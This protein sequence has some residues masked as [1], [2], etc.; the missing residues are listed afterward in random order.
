MAQAG[1]GTGRPSAGEESGEGALRLRGSPE[2]VQVPLSAPGLPGRSPAPIWFCPRVVVTIS[3]PQLRKATREVCDCRWAVSTPGPPPSPPQARGSPL[4]GPR[5]TQGSG[6]GC[7]SQHNRRT[8][9]QLPAGTSTT[10]GSLLSTGTG[11]GEKER[12]ALESFL[13]TTEQT[14]SCSQTHFQGSGG[15]TPTFCSCKIT[16]PAF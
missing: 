15:K 14:V 7:S 5:P 12:E 9:T 10:L 6:Q 8:R 3:G 11:A 16:K 2:W 4:P 1:C 13:R